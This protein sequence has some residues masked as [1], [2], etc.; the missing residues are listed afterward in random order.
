MFFIYRKSFL[1]W[2]LFFPC[3]G[4]RRLF[5][6]ADWRPPTWWNHQGLRAQRGGRL[7]LHLR[8]G[9]GPAGI[10]PRPQPFLPPFL[11]P[12]QHQTIHSCCF[13]PFLHRGRLPE[14]HE[15]RCQTQPSGVGP[16]E[17][18]VLLHRTRLRGVVRGSQLWRAEPGGHLEP[19]L[20]GRLRG[21]G[22]VLPGLRLRAAGGEVR[23]LAR[24]DGAG[25]RDRDL[26]G[27][28]RRS[29]HW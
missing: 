25:Q 27:P 2:C 3:R 28:G 4:E 6:P 14:A 16:S 12:L 20:T 15:H 7:R 24:S 23:A 19:L 13:C 17:G 8:C 9:F 21:A 5:A 22:D 10:G 1:I 29:R 11:P 26:C 18:A